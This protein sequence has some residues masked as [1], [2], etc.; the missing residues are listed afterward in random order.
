MKNVIGI[1]IFTNQDVL[2]HKL[3][4]GKESNDCYCY[5]EMGRFPKRFIDSNETDELRLYMAIKG[6]VKGYFII[7]DYDDTLMFYSE[8]WHIIK[9]GEQLKPSQGF[10]YYIHKNKE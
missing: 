7:H 8:S 3:K 1:L 5:W 10:R 2:D 9:D 6:Q 4:D